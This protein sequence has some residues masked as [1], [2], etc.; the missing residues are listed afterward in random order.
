M[1]Y[2][3]DSRCC[4]LSG[5]SY[6]E[7]DTIERE[8]LDDYAPE[9]DEEEEESPETEEHFNEQE[10]REPVRQARFLSHLPKLKRPAIV[11]E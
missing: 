5:V 7:P 10:L 3:G 2:A 6:P 4:S 1:G 9:E 11:V 8:D